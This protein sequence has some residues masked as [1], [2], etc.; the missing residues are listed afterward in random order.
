MTTAAADIG[1][2]GEVNWEL[3]L[4]NANAAGAV[5]EVRVEV[6]EIANRN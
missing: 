2:V 5:R 4:K 6:N 1:P 3:P